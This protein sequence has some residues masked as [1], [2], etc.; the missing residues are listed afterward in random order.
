MNGKYYK[1]DIYLQNRK[2]Y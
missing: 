2:F 1:W